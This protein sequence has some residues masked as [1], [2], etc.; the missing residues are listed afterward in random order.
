MKK[1]WKGFAGYLMAATLICGMSVIAN[2]ADTAPKY[3]GKCG[4]NATW[5]YNK[6][7]QTM[8]ISGEGTIRNSL[9]WDELYI[10][11][12]TIKSGLTKIGESAFESLYDLSTVSIPDTV[13]AIEDYAFSDSGIES[14]TIGA[15]V[16]KIGTEV[17]EDCTDLKTVNWYAKTIPNYTFYNCTNLKNINIKSTLKSIGKYAFKGTAM[18]TFTMPNSVTTVGNNAFTNC[19]KLNN[20][21][22]S[23][24]VQTIPSFIAYNTP[25]LQK[26]VIKDGTKTISKKA[27]AK[28]GAKEII[29]PNSVTTIGKE[30]FSNAKNLKSIKFPNKVS[31]INDSTFKGCKNLESLNIGKNI[32]Y[33][34]ECAFMNC[35]NLKTIDIPGN[36]KEIDYKAFENSGCQKV[37]IENG[38]AEI[39]YWAFHD[40]DKL[41][42]ISISNTVTT[43]RPNALVDCDNLTDIIVSADNPKYSSASGCL[44]DKS[45]ATLLVVPAGKSGVFN[46]PAP[47]SKVETTAFCG[48]G[49]ITEITATNSASFSSAD[50]ILYSKD[51][52]T[53]ISC[54]SSKS[55]TIVIPSTVIRIEESAFQQSK[56][57]YISIPAS[58]TSIGYCAF[59]YCENLTSIDIP[60]SVKKVSNAAFWGCKNLRKVTI[61]NGVR[62]IQRNAFHDCSKLQKVI[63]PTSVYKISKSAF[64]SLYNVTF[65][66]RKSSYAMS[67]AVKYYINYKPI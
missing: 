47:I 50:G 49:K 60:G 31:Q 64:K 21:I 45:Q 33:I 67:F 40:C 30:A 20:L 46:I 19:K 43:L 7:T 38:V 48:C 10:K 2:A 58:V 9:D 36:V 11:H 1:L 26:I 17:F 52:K 54:P 22:F 5:T 62:K 13:T 35:S 55:G 18:K 28:C 61:E 44:L 34:G 63:I 57:S 3:H 23:K 14:I 53:L 59:E 4:K 8:T 42:S 66:C 51:M 16:K 12:I 39:E 15:S 65:Y 56:A 25:N 27:F 41:K 24:N 32:N 29:I 37:T 6:P